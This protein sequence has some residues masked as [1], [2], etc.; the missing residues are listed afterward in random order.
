MLIEAA[1]DCC[2][3]G[4]GLGGPDGFDDDND[5]GDPRPAA[6]RGVGVGRTALAVHLLGDAA[7]CAAVLAEALFLRFG[8]PRLP[9]RA[10]R[11]LK[12]YLDPALSLAISV[13]IALAAWPVGSRAA[14]SLLGLSEPTE[15]LRS[16]AL[17]VDGVARV[18]AAAIMVLRDQPTSRCG[19]A[20][21]AVDD[22]AKAVPAANAVRDLLRRR[23][24]AKDRTFVDVHLTR[25]AVEALRHARL[26]VPGAGWTRPAPTAR[27]SAIGWAQSVVGM[28]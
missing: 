20:R 3:P 1:C 14:K 17:A 24:A 11:G 13:A 21:V 9:R 8:A 22:A 27:T 12:R 4:V 6:S 15:K 2:A 23:G 18:D 28:V 10:A 25:E 16:R 7:T 19:M 26:A 5:D